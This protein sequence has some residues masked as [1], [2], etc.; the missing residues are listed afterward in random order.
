[1]FAPRRTLTK[2]GHRYRA[3]FRP[4]FSLHSPNIP[5]EIDGVCGVA[6]RYA[7]YREYV[8]NLEEHVSDFALQEGPLG[9]AAL[10]TGGL[11]ILCPE[12]EDAQIFS[13]MFSSTL[14][15]F[16][17][18]RH[19]IPKKLAHCLNAMHWPQTCSMIK[20]PGQSKMASNGSICIYR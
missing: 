13:R 9:T 2:L 7:A 8:G 10:G 3:A 19:Y 20:A 11:C 6:L 14:D 18:S 5:P 17:Q 16:F 4:F 15:M 1:M 12:M